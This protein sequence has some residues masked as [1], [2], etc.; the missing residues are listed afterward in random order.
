MVLALAACS[1]QPSASDTRADQIRQ[2]GEDAG[3]PDD[4]IEVLELAARGVD[5]TFQIT[6]PGDKGASVVISQAPP[7][8]RIDVLAGERVVESRVF[9]DG[10]GYHCTPPSDDPVGS[11]DCARSESGLDAPGAFSEEALTTFAKDLG[12]L[13][14]VELKVDSRTVADTDATCLVAGDETIC[15]S[16]EGAQLLVDTGGDRLAATSYTTKVPDGTFDT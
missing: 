5:G 3:L 9:R 10:V 6:Y 13:D 2:V 15:L 8:R 11:L 14:D 1:D 16:D 4:V 7:N 12:K